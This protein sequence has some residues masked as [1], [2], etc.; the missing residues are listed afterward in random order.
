MPIT[1]ENLIGGKAVRGANGE[2]RALDPA[3]GTKLEPAF[4]GATKADLEQACALAEA[5]FDEYRNRPLEERAAF[6]EAIADNIMALGDEL[7]ERCVAESGLP[8]GRIEGERGRTVGQLRFFADIVR[9]KTFLRTVKDAADE[10]RKPARK[11]ELRAHMIGLGPVAIFSASNFPLAFSIAGGD[12]ASALAAGCPVVTKAHSAH[13]G[14]SELVGR[15]VQKAVADKG[16]PVGTFALLFDTGRT[17]GQGLVA[18]ARIM[19]VGFTGSRGGGTAL[20]KI[21]QDRPVPIPVYA[22]MSSIN[23]VLLMPGALAERGEAIATAFAQSVTLGSGQFCTNPGLILAVEGAELTAFETAAAAA[24]GGIAAQTMLTPGI[25]KAFADGVLK[26]AGNPAVTELGRGQPGQGCQ[27]SRR[28]SPFRVRTSR[29]IRRCTRRCSV[30]HRWSSA[31]RTKVNCA[32]SSRRSR[33][34]SPSRCISRSPMESGS[35]RCC[36][37]SSAR[38]ADCSS[39]A[40]EPVSRSPPPWCMAGP[41]RPR[42][43]GVPPRSGPWP[44]TASCGRCP[45][46][47]SRKSYFRSTCAAFRAWRIPEPA[48]L[49][50]AGSASGAIDITM[51]LPAAMCAAC[52]V[53][54]SLCDVIRRPSRN[55]RDSLW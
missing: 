8:R 2:A 3:T 27:G 23:P 19:A 45:T 22:E 43:T 29:P 34:S 18:D 1:G 42:R 48:P 10:T 50:L 16:M 6:L 13:L 11:P 7:I 24:L 54:A 41:T 26:L 53:R 12:T 55:W 51:G 49:R 35:R 5:A 28:C 36:R 52:A 14:T 37:C 21:A 4:G 25:H 17:I 40:S 44:S 9:K 32:R 30:P 46:R 47:T 20:M 31:A 15:A 33:A 38:P 39:T